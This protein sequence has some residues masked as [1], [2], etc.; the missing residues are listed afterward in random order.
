MLSLPSEAENSHDTAT[1][2]ASAALLDDIDPREIIDGSTIPAC[3]AELELGA[4]VAILNDAPSPTCAAR[5]P[6]A[7]SPAPALPL[8]T[9]A[10]S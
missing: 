9:F 6:P 10:G 7:T 4:L 1:A 8:P 2:P 5:S 3:A